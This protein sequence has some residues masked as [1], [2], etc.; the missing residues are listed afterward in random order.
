MSEDNGLQISEPKRDLLSPVFSVQQYVWLPI[1]TIQCRKI[2]ARSWSLASNKG[3]RVS[4]RTSA[5]RRS[6]S[7]QAAFQA[8]RA[9]AMLLYFVAATTSGPNCRT[10]AASGHAT[11]I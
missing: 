7:T 8:V 4:A 5:H 9:R 11:I 6:V 10:V 3:Q 1:D 2:P